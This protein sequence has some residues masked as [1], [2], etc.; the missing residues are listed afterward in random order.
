MIVGEAARASGLPAKTLRYYEE[1]GLVA[2][3]R[4]ANGYRDYSRR[5][6]HKLH[7]LQ[8]ARSLGF[9]IQDCR[10]LLSLYEDDQRASAD[11]RAVAQTHLKKIDAKIRELKSLR[12]TLSEL[13]ENCHGDHRPDC[14]I[15]D[16]LSGDTDR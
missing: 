5:D 8:R 15:L 9:S 14:P 12:A 7:F 16:S 13:V 4:R 10:H 6:I 11:V 2:P 1:I 3:A